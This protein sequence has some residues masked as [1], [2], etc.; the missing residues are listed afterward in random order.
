MRVPET[1][2]SVPGSRPTLE[3]GQPRSTPATRSKYQPT[4]VRSVAGEVPRTSI[5]PAPPETVKRSP[6][7]DSSTGIRVNCAAR[8]GSRRSR[9]ARAGAGSK[10]TAAPGRV[11]PGSVT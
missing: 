10:G 5:A 4:P 9:L 8:D 3:P 6:E 1:A 11:P 2:G 7:A